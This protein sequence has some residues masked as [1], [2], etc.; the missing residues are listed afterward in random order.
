METQKI[1]N[2]NIVFNTNNIQLFF[3]VFN[4]VWFSNYKAKNHISRDNFSMSSKTKNTN[5]I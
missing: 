2:N 3:G 4:S 5:A 1:C